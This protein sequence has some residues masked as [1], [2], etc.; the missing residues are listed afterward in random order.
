[1][2]GPACVPDK[3]RLTVTVTPLSGDSRYEGVGGQRIT[4]GVGVGTVPKVRPEGHHYTFYLRPS[5]SLG[6]ITWRNTSAV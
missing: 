6:T 1:M 2:Y 5:T 3:Y 4:R